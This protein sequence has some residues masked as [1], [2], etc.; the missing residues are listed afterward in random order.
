M[1]KIGR[2][3]EESKIN[4]SFTA[5]QIVI[6]FLLHCIK[7]IPMQYMSIYQV[8]FYDLLSHTYDHVGTVKIIN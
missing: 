6:T 8:V 2:G 5:L 7:N 4:I 1:L 3:F